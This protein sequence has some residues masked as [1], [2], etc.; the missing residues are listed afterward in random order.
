MAEEREVLASS[1]D[2]GGS[3]DEECEASPRHISIE[4]RLISQGRVALVER[5]D[6][7]QYWKDGVAT[8]LGRLALRVCPPEDA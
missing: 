6:D 7:E 2:L 8:D 5:E 3:P 4:D 1:L